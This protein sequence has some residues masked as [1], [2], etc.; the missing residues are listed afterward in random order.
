ML[1]FSR[2]L[3]RLHKGGQLKIG[4]LCLRQLINLDLSNFEYEIFVVVSAGRCSRQNQNKYSKFDT[5]AAHQFGLVK[6]WILNICCCFCR[7]VQWTKS[8][9]IF[10][11]RHVL[12]N[13]LLRTLPSLKNQFLPLFTHALMRQVKSLLAK[14]LRTHV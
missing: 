1:S 3:R 12:I 11:I 9:Q 6:F 5:S 2:S 7:Q 14:H 13:K 8:K 10:K 4:N